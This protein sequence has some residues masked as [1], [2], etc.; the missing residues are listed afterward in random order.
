MGSSTDV[1][2]KWHMVKL[3]QRFATQTLGWRAMEQFMQWCQTTM[4]DPRGT[5][6]YNYKCDADELLYRYANVYTALQLTSKK[7]PKALGKPEAG[8]QNDLG[9]KPS[10]KELVLARFARSAIAWQSVSIIGFD[11]RER[12]YLRVINK[13][14]DNYKKSAN[15]TGDLES[16]LLKAYHDAMEWCSY[17]FQSRSDQ[18]SHG[19]KRSNRKK[20]DG[21]GRENHAKQD[22]EDPT[23]VM[24]TVTTE[25]LPI[26]LGYCKN[27]TLEP[28]DDVKA[29]MRVFATEEDA[30]YD[31][32][33]K[34]NPYNSKI[35]MRV[36]PKGPVE[37]D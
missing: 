32:D 23:V 5:E 18:K 28:V 21:L 12:D 19:R 34:D 3:W 14:F 10:R 22:R 31:A 11:G 27:S 20:R 1:E 9:P 26:V 29:P 24:E 36:L 25:P 15:K 35:P 4:D 13:A 16:Q 37:T 17:K 2:T 33:G 8:A 30:T 7:T 6:E